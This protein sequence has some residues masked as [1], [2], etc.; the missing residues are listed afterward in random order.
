MPYTVRLFLT[1]SVY[2]RYKDRKQV[3]SHHMDIEQFALSFL[4]II[5]KLKLQRKKMLITMHRYLD[6]DAFGS[7]LALGLMLRKLQVE[8]TL[9]CVPFIPD[10]F[11]FLKHESKLQVVELRH[12]GQED[13]QGYYTRALQDYFSDKIKD[14]GA[15][16]ILDCAGFGQ[17]PKEVW[18]IG[19]QIPH[20]LN[21]DHHL[22]YALD[23]PG[24]SILNLVENC[25]S[26]CEVLFH[27]M[28][29]INLKMDRGIALPLY[30]GTH[31]DLRKNAISADSPQ[32]PK[33]L[34]SALNRQIKQMDQNIKNQIKD[35]FSLDP[36]EKKLLEIAMNGI[37]HIEN[38]V[39]VSFDSDM[40]FAAKK[41]TDS[42][43]NPRM[44]FHEFHI[45][46]RQKLSQF[47]KKFQIVVI[48]DQILD[49]VSL[50]DLRKEPT[51]DLAAISR[52]LGEG[53]GHPNRAGFSYQ[54]AKKKFMIHHMIED[55]DSEDVIIES[56]VCFIKKRISEMAGDKPV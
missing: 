32:Y 50:Y 11:Q 24:N 44:P 40:V 18:M 17:V 37:R 22:G 56:M 49:K 26:T 35:I 2:G 6:G 39:Y 46:L 55:G 41:E 16:A 27:L 28:Q 43:D 54:T 8:S 25:S 48:F 33:R 29:K 7:G 10:K 38:M 3:N 31:A 52:E 19:R 23:T 14:Y 34:V 15:L 42:L 53:G 5:K 13:H 36:W 4:D 12:L 9:I 1:T 30:I 21:I 45:R 20:I 51:V 47:K